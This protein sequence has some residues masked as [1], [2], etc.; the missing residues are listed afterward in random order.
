MARPVR[1]DL[2]FGN[3]AKIINLPSPTNAGDAVN[4]SYVDTRLEGL[5]WKESCRVATTAN[6]DLSNPPSSIDGITLA[7]ND[8]ILVKDQT[9]ASQ[10]GIYV[11][12]GTGNPLTR[13]SDADTAEELRAAVVVVR[14][15]TTN[16]DTTWMQTAEISNLGTD[17][18]IWQQFGVS[19]PDASET[20]KGKVEIAT[21]AE[22]DAG[23]LDAPYAVT[24][25][26]LA[27]SIWAKKKY[28]TDI[29]D[30][31][32]TSYAIT[33]NLGTRDVYVSI[34]KNSGNYEEVIAEVRHTDA[35]TITVVF[36]SAPAA[37]EYRVV[38]IG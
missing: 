27:S 19:V 23:T 26:K 4:K 34:Y 15:G 20:V 21:Q 31:T 24:P 37:N 11:Y 13:A 30:G 12:N 7:V 3:V 32:N 10:N 36:A 17:D 18:V 38:V 29:G 14:E 35:N 5:K 25:L 2:D 16:A 1:V 28:V 22:V 6:I 9:T 8:R 33:H